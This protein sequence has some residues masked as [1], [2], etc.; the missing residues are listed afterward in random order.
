MNP[1]K[2]LK[3]ILADL[4]KQKSSPE[5]IALGAAIG[6]CIGF[7]PWYGIQIYIVLLCAYLIR[8]ANK[9]AV[10]AGAQINWLALLYYP[11]EYKLGL[12]LLRKQGLTLTIETFRHLTWA[13][14]LHNMNMGTMAGILWPLFIGSLIFGAVGSVITY[15]I[16]RRLVVRARA[17]AGAE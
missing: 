14:I 3:K 10:V 7:S 17:R 12:V 2:K 9:V 8:R 1:V 5:E 15:F 6:I 11:F 13:K 4:V 16:V